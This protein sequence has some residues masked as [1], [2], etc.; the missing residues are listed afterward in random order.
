MLDDAAPGGVGASGTGTSG[1]AGRRLSRLLARRRD[2]GDRGRRPGPAPGPV[3]ADHRRPVLA[4]RRSVTPR[5]ARSC[6]G[7]TTPAAGWPHLR[8]AAEP[9]AVTASRDRRRRG[10]RVAAG[11]P[12]AQGSARY[13]RPTVRKDRTHAGLLLRP[14]RQVRRRHRRAAGRPDVLPAGDLGGPD[15]HASPWRR[16]R[17][18][19]WPS[20]STSFSTRCCGAPGRPRG[21]RRVAADAARRRPARPAAQRGLPGRRDRPG[22][23]Q[24]RRAGDH[25]GSGAQRGRRS[26][27]CRSDVPVDGPAVLRVRITPSAARAFAHRALKVVAPGGRRARCA[28]CRSTP[29]G[30]SARGRTATGSAAVPAQARRRCRER[31]DARAA[32]GRTRGARAARARQADRGGPPGRRVQRDALLHDQRRR[33]RRPPASTSRSRGSARCGTSR[34]H[35]GRP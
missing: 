20:G 5:C 6:S 28:G 33:D 16:S 11:R 25:R 27:R 17:S 34:R 4:D 15:D 31:A 14:A 29:T 18:S 32:G 23:G 8:P 24:R 2:Q 9:A 30:T 1:S 22:L 35:A 26:S 12:A 19:S 21:S 7:S 3:P 13:R 10:T